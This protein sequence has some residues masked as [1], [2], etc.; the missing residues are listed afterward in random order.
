MVEIR[1]T[2]RWDLTYR[3][4]LELQYRLQRQIRLR[5]LA[6]KRIRHVAGTDV[7][8]SKKLGSLIAA[9]VVLSFPELSIVETRT[10]CTELAFPYIPGLLSFREIP[11]LI[12]CLRKVHTPFEVLLC[13]GQGIAHPRRFGLASHIGVLLAI[14]TIGCAKSRLLGEHRVVGPRKGDVVPLSH[15]GKRVGSVLR[16]R[17][18]VKPIFVSPGHLVD[19]PSARR[20]VLACAKGYRVPEPTRQAHIVAGRYKQLLEKGIG[21]K[22]R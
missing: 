11:G 2:H 9:I 12:Q 21:K 14:P 19:H 20:I 8:V 1:E 3:E 5:P 18:K 6:L 17:E 7:A 13:D 16:T 15:E 4:A 22:R 10:A